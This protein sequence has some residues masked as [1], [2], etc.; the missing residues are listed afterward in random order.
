MIETMRDEERERMTQELRDLRDSV[1]RIETA[2]LGSPMQPDSGLVRKVIQLEAYRDEDKAFK[3]KAV[4][5]LGVLTALFS[6]ITTFI[7]KL[8]N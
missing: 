6:I 5:A 8:I 1:H 4:G 2:L 3:H 7:G